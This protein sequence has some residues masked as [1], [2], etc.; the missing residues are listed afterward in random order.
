MNK[1]FIIIFLVL[2]LFM[3]FLLVFF[4][5]EG[6]QK[7]FVELLDRFD[8]T[9]KEIIQIKS[10]SGTN[11]EYVSGRLMRFD[12]EKLT[13]MDMDENLLWQKT[14]L[15]SNLTFT[16]G[17]S[18]V[19]V[20]NKEIGEIY[21]YNTNG[22][23]LV[24]LKLEKE[25]YLV[26]LFEK[27]IAIHSKI[28][29][30]DEIAFYD[31]NGNLIKELAYNDSYLINYYMEH[32]DIFTV[33]LSQNSTGFTSSLINHSKDNNTDFSIDNEII[34]RRYSLGSLDVYLTDE[35]V[36][37]IKSQ[38]IL[39]EK[40]FSVIRDVL[41]DG[42][43]IYILYGNNLEILNKDGESKVKFSLAL[44]YKKIYRHGKYIII[45]GEK[46]LIAY[47]HNTEVGRFYFLRKTKDINTQFNE[48]VVS[49]ED[50][51]S[52]LRIEDMVTKEE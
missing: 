48:L 49:L 41:I 32:G 24:E 45:V 30:M 47:L 36:K 6:N 2:F 16:K 4:S 43:D 1:K 22:E 31:Y 7:K 20:Y 25:I 5:F 8:N 10:I 12:G 27:G 29:A 38:E 19:S 33:E 42:D 50:G 46:D 39:W 15:L 9:E 13:T 52:V 28:D 14:F 18:K 44:E 21:V 23:T 35:G 40:E 3:G 17:D 37:A 26:N 34:I 11:L 51:I